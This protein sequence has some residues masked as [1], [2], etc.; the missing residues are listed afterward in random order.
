MGEPIFYGTSEWSH[1]TSVHKFDT[2][3]APWTAIDRRIPS[4]TSIHR[5]MRFRSRIVKKVCQAVRCALTA[6]ICAQGKGARMFSQGYVAMAGRVRS[7]ARVYPVQE[8]HGTHL[9]ADDDRS[10]VGC[11]SAR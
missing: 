1:K 8:M 5:G 4:R 3:C 6:A 2:E 9:V 11:E 10:S 7:A